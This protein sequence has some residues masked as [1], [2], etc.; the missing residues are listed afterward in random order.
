MTRI[1]K[2]FRVEPELWLYVINRAA[3]LKITP[4]AWLIRCI[5]DAKKR[6]EGQ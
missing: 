1:V 2:A 5:K 3:A 6:Q 4:S